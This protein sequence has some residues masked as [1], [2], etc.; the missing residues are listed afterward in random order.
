VWYN[1][2]VFFLENLETCL[3]LRKTFAVLEIVNVDERGRVDPTTELSKNFKP[4]RDN[5]INLGR[6]YQTFR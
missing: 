3:R 2:R 4:F 1:K 6:P 5:L